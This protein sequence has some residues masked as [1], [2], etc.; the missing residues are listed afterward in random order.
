LR[1]T[2]LRAPGGDDVVGMLI[3]RLQAP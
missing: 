1:Q 3:R 2:R